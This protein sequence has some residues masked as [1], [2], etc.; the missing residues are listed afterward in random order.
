MCKKIYEKLV[1]KMHPIKNLLEDMKLPPLNKHSKEKH[2]IWTV[3]NT[4]TD[5]SNV[6]F[7]MNAVHRPD[8]C[9]S[10]WILYEIVT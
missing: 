9:N 10:S 4:K 5:F 3:K 1:M 2:V 6:F 8:T 7:L